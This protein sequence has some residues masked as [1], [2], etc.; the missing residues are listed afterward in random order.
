MPSCSITRGRRARVC[1]G[2]LDR[3]VTIH[4]RAITPP[5]YGTPDF[6]EAFTA[7]ATIWALIKSVDGK[8]FFDGVNQV[9]RAI[10]HEIWIRYDSTVTAESWVELSGVLYDILRVED[11]DNR[12]EFV[13]L[14]C[15]ERGANSTPA[16][17]I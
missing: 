14:T 11:M 10:T 9:D 12:H 4:N 1:L 16:A 7:S 15:S 8:T 2:D 13:K 17:Q 6:S 3:R 5:L